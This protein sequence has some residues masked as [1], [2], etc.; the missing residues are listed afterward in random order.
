[1]DNPLLRLLSPQ[2]M[3][4]QQ[5]SGAMPVMQ[6]PQMQP[7]QMAPNKGMNFMRDLVAGA[8]L[9]Y[10]GAGV[11]PI[12]N[13]QEQR[14]KRE[15]EMLEQ[16]KE[17]AQINQTKAWLKSQGR[18]DLVSLVDA[19]Q[20]ST[21]L[22]IATQKPEK[23]TPYTEA[24][25]AKADLDQGYI[26]QEQYQQIV[27]GQGQDN[28]YAQREKAALDFGLTPDSPAYQSFVLTGKMPRE[29]QAPLTAT[30]KKAILEADDMVAQNE[31]AV[32]ALGQAEQYS[33]EANSGMLAG[34]RAWLGN[35]LPD[36]L[37]PDFIASKESSLA[38]S[39]LD[40]V[41]MGQALSSMKAI[42]GGNPT[43]GE[44]AILLELQ[45][46]SSMSKP[47]R[48]ALL[49]RA[50]ALAQRRLEFNQQRAASLRG[51]DYYKTGAGGQPAP[52]MGGAPDPLGIR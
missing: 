15:E 8:L 16:G 39:N 11:Q 1:M 34:T 17:Q 36:L 2:P 46:S 23:P 51:G 21:A 32:Q 18:E 48:A 24:A 43:E 33:P 28:V 35:K 44:R 5:G 20:A 40:N 22:Q 25:R 38:T 13:A 30:D 4:Y 10:G 29:D 12:L 52:Q 42:F 6:Q 37:V 45:A 19:G 31:A 26:T 50:K 47:E 27:S 7:Q 3:Q 9:S 49:K 41:V 14:R